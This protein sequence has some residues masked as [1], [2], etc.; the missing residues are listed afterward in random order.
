VNVSSAA[1][2][3]VQL[4]QQIFRDRYSKKHDQ[5]IPGMRQFEVITP[6]QFLC[7]ASAPTFSHS[8][9]V[10]LAPCDRTIVEALE[11]LVLSIGTCMLEFIKKRGKK[12][13]EEE[14]DDN[15]ADADE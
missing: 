6:W 8:G 3:H 2:I 14:E 15:D 9:D 12:A 4:F 1:T 7:A 13:I 10:V 5:P 11:H